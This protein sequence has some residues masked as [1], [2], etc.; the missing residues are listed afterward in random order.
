MKVP[1][2]FLF[3]LF[4]EQDARIRRQLAEKSLEISTGRKYRNISDN[5]SSTYNVLELKK[6][7]SQLSQYSKNRLFAD[8][9]LSYADFNLEKITDTLN[10]L[11]ARAIQAKN[12]IIQPDQLVSIGNFFNAALKTLIDRANERLGENYIFGGA[13]LT[14]KPFDENTLRYEA[15]AENFS[16]WLSD[17]YRVDTFLRGDQVF[18]VNVAVSIASFASPGTNFNTAGTLAIS[19]GAS[20]INVSYSTTQ[21]LNDLT[22]FINSNY[23]NLVNARIA[24]TSSGTYSLVLIPTEVSKE[25]SVSDTT[26]GD[27]DLGQVD[28]NSPNVLQVVRDIGQKLSNGIHPDDTDL[29]IL[30]RAFERISYRRS[31]VGASLSQ[32]KNLQPVQENFSDNLNKQKSEL[33][34]AELSQSIM[35]YTRYRIAYEA[36]MRIIAEQKDMSILRYVR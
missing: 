13:S 3:S 5:P 1:D 18:G 19:I 36:L 29:A 12:Q 20:N 4:Q 8:T 15:S 21:T 14:Q 24:Q 10:Q 22:N 23:S 28:F 31:Q 6:D 7:I 35:D 30:Q 2:N 9:A 11:Y 26:G 34:D 16:V 32:V 17:N 27:F 25:I 33:E